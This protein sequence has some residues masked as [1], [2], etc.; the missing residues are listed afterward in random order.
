MRCVCTVCCLPVTLWILGT[1]QHRQGW[2]QWP[3]IHEEA[4]AQRD[5]HMTGLQ[6]ARTPEHGPQATNLRT[7]IV[8]PKTI[9]FW[10]PVNVNRDT[11]GLC[12][13][14]QGCECP[15]VTRGRTNMVDTM[16][17]SHDCL[18][19][20]GLQCPC[21]MTPGAMHSL[22]LCWFFLLSCYT[23]TDLLQELSHVW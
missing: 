15:C 22:A 8:V 16:D 20:L 6:Q 10:E 3:F 2:L 18:V 17:G 12:Y 4:E 9:G 11:W 23:M 7:R 14:G 13:Q 19:T 21:L 1:V 5:G